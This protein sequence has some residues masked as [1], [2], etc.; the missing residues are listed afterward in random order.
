[1]ENCFGP[2]HKFQ[3]VNHNLNNETLESL[4]IPVW[5]RSGII[6]RWLPPL[7][8]VTP[9]KHPQ[10]ATF[11]VLLICEQVNPDSNKQCLKLV[12]NDRN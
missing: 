10:F 6:P 7:L 8:A 9:F 2:L 3:Y 11:A 1:M 12:L 4:V 5:E